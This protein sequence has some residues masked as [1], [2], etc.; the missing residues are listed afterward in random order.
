ML[1]FFFTIT[2]T[3]KKNLKTVLEIAQPNLFYQTKFFHGCST[4]TFVINSLTDWL[5]FLMLCVICYISCVMCHIVCLEGLVSMELA[6][7]S[8]FFLLLFF[9][10][11]HILKLEMRIFLGY[12]SL[13]FCDY[14]YLL[15]SIMLTSK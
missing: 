6:P 8:C 1:L 14:F 9:L 13:R 5:I 15:V 4:N 12:V 10:T 11:S 2:I 7:S 3:F